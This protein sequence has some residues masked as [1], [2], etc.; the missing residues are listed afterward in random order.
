MPLSMRNRLCDRRFNFQESCEL[1]RRQPAEVRGLLY[2]K[3]PPLHEALPSATSWSRAD[4]SA[5]AA[6]AVDDQA[7]SALRDTID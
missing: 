3:S 2:G 6:L 5:S 7:S 4:E 1:G